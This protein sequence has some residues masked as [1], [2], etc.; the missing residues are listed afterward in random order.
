[1]VLAAT[2]DTQNLT[3]EHDLFDEYIFNEARWSPSP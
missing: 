3:G 2:A 1:M